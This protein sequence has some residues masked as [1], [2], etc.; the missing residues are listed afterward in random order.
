V[1][2]HGKPLDVNAEWLAQYAEDVIDPALP[3]V[4]PHHHLWHR[5]DGRYL[6]EDFAEDIR[7]GHN[8]VSTVY[9]QARSMY[10]KDAPKALQSI[11][12]TEFSLT[13]LW[14][15]NPDSS[16]RLFLRRE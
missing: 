3:I 2:T 12:E 15:N 13:R 9:I 11:G 7:S 8:I 4:D 6:A 16:H 10:R 5:P 1:S 14:S